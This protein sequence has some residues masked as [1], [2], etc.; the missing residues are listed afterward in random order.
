MSNTSLASNEI[1]NWRRWRLARAPESTWAVIRR[2]RRLWEKARD[3]TA[4]ASNRPTSTNQPPPGASCSKKM[5]ANAMQK[6]KYVTSQGK[7]VRSKK[8]KPVIMMGTTEGNALRIFFSS[9]R[10]SQRGMF[11]SVMTTA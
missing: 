3:S 8:K 10:P 9:S 2:T 6:K 1:S 11:M 4:M 7:A 5:L